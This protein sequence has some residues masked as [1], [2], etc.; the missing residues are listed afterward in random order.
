MSI[1]ALLKGGSARALPP[2][3]FSRSTCS[4][5]RHFFT[6]LTPG[7]TRLMGLIRAAMNHAPVTPYGSFRS[8]YVDSRGFPSSGQVIGKPAFFHALIPPSTLAMF[9]KPRAASR[10][11]ETDDR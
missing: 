7:N 8:K 4:R 1:H 5:R 3:R 9:L 6:S 10:L 2:L 11:E